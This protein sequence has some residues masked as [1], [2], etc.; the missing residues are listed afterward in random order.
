MGVH[1]LWSLL[2]PA[3]RRVKL[4]TLGGKIMAIDVSIWLLKMIHGYLALGNEEYRNIHLI[5]IFRRIVKLLYYG[6]KPVFVF[7]GQPPELKRETI[8]RRQEY[9][10][11]R[12]V[13]LKKVAEKFFE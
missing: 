5:G 8:R 6:I 1:G 13:N 7:E 2:S 12:R 3:G 11:N 10:E 4:E 9:R